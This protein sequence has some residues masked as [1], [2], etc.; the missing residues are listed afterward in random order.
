M[1]KREAAISIVV[2][3]KPDVLARIA[4][5]FSG[6]GFNIESISANVT[7]DPAITKIIITTIGTQDTITKIEKQINRLVD[8]LVARDISVDE[9]VQR[10]MLL[11][12]MKPA[13]ADRNDL[14]KAV[15]TN[16]WK[17]IGQDDTYLFIE[18]TGEREDIDRALAVLEPLGMEDFSRTGT[19]VIERRGP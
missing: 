19:V 3:N 10:E 9:A 18:V 4:G 2:N 13:A 7:R 8:V 5:T 11:I 6:R 16:G 15:I 14:Y 17:I 12:R 1:S